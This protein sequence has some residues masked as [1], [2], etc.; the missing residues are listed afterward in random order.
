[1]DPYFLYFLRCSTRLNA[2]VKLKE[3]H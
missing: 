3:A 2:L 1:V